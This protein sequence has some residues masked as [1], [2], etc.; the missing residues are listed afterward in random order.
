MVEELVPR[1][2]PGD[3]NARGGGTYET[4]KTDLVRAESR[5]TLLTQQRVFAVEARGGRIIAVVAQQTRT[6][7]RV[8]LAAKLFADCTGDGTV[9]FLAGADYEMS[10]ENHQGLSNRWNVRDVAD[11]MQV[12][13][14]SARTRL[15]WPWRRR[16]E[17]LRGSASRDDCL[18]MWS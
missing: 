9:G 8:R 17:T 10:R 11:R 13:G 14:T 1:K 3:G 6:S 16:R 12:L 7:R 5:I 4:R 2:G 15:R 18:E